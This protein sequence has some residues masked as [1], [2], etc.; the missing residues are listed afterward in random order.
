MTKMIFTTDTAKKWIK[1]SADLLEKE[2]ETLTQLDQ[3]LGDGDHGLNMTRGFRAAVNEIDQFDSI[4]A[5]F[6]SVSQT[7]LTKVGGASGP[8]YGT[9]F[10]K[11]SITLKELNE[12]SMEQLGEAL[13]EAANGMKQRGKAEEGDKTLIDIWVPVARLLS[14]NK[15]NV[16][17]EDIRAAAKHALEA[18]NDL[19]AKKGRAS[20]YKERSIGHI[21][22]GAQS[23]Y[24]LMDALIYALQEEE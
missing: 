21:D 18:S 16:K 19:E 4:G 17:V 10:L 23:S 22:P 14:E 20:Y 1:H 7:L 8:L 3:A 2:K 12:A 6:R 11:M 9:A 15:E 5:V 24:Y 13:R